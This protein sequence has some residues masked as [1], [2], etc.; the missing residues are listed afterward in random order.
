MDY[1]LPLY[2]QIKEIILTQI[3]EKELLPGEKIPSEREMAAIYGINRMTVKRAVSALVSEGVLVSVHGKGTF[4]ATKKANKL[5]YRIQSSQKSVGFGA[6]LRE[7]GLKQ[8]DK[9]IASGRIKAGNYLS[10]KLNL[11]KED[12]VYVLQRLRFADDETLA[13]E[14]CYMPFKFVPDISVYN[15]EQ[16]SLYAYLESRN[17]LP[18]SFLQSLIIIESSYSES[19]LLQIE[20]GSPLYLFEYLGSDQEGN[21]IEYTQSYLRCDKA[22]FTY[23]SKK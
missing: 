7:S 3:H 10:K 15:F 14:Y 19:K 2:L 22:I 12:D 8:N 13:L 5:V 20:K 11:N 18:V 16:V 4:V 6:L 9:I 23:Y 17:H 1:R 21:T